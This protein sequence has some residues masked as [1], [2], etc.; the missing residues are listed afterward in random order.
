MTE[1]YPKIEF[2]KKVSNIFNR[3]VLSLTSKYPINIALYYDNNIILR[4]SEKYAIAWLKTNTSP[5][6]LFNLILENPPMVVATVLDGGVTRRSTIRPNKIITAYLDPDTD[7][8]SITQQQ[9]RSDLDP[10]ILTQIVD[11]LG[12]FVRYIQAPVRDDGLTDHANERRPWLN[13]VNKALSY[14]DKEWMYDFNNLWNANR[15]TK[16]FAGN[17]ITATT[18]LLNCD[19]PTSVRHELEAIYNE[20]IRIYEYFESDHKRVSGELTRLSKNVIEI[21]RGSKDF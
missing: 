18:L 5:E 13:G 11:C 7:A 15:Y 10:S 6:S 4:N 2:G 17:L 3:F 14:I 8:Y 9:L 16:G 12:T 19:L 21:F 1:S 20:M